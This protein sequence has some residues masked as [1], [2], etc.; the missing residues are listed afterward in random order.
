M[1]HIDKKFIVYRS[2]AGSGKTFTLVREYLQLVLQDPE[3]FRH[4]LA[5][6]FTN[7]AANEMKERIIRY[8]KTLADPARNPDTV[9]QKFL[10]PELAGATGLSE[11]AIKNRA[12][13]AL[14]SLMHQY[15]DFAVST[16][17]SF[18]H[19]VVRTFAHDLNIPLS[20]EVVL[21]EIDALSEVVSLL[22]DRV[23]VDE[24]LTRVLVK[25]IQDK[26]EDERSWDIEKDLQK[27]SSVLVRESS[28]PYLERVS[29]LD[30]KAVEEARDLIWKLQRAFEEEVAKMAIALLKRLESEGLDAADMAGGKYGLMPWL[31]KLAGK[32]FDRLEPYKAIF[33]AQEKDFWASAK[34]GAAKKA[35][36]ESLSAEINLAF[37]ALHRF[38]EE[39]K[40][41]Y[42][43]LKVITGYLYPM[44]VLGA[45]DRELQQYRE[46]NNVLLISEFNR[47][48]NEIIREQPVPFIYER[49]G[50]KY[51]HFMI[52]EFQDTSLL[53]WQNLLPLMENS[54]S[55]GRMNL[56]VGD[57]KQAIY[58]FRSGDVRQFE[59]LP[60]MLQPPDDPVLKSREDSLVRNFGL[61][62]LKDNFRS[63]E[64]VVSFNNLFFTRAR[65]WLPENMQNIFEDVTQGISGKAGGYVSIDFV[66]ADED[67]RKFEEVMMD[68]VRGTVDELLA[69]GFKQ[70]DIAILC[71]DNKNTSRIA[72]MLISN[73]RQVIS[74]DSL[75]L[76]FSAEVNFLVA[77]LRYLSNTADDISRVHILHYLVRKGSLDDK[78]LESYLIDTQRPD[79]WKESEAFTR[80][81]NNKFNIIL[82]KNFGKQD[83]QEWLRLDLYHLVGELIRLFIPLKEADPYLQFFHDQVLEFI[84]KEYHSLSDFL[85][86]WDDKGNM[87]SIVTPEGLDA[88]RIMTIHK[89]KGLEFPVVI[90]PFADTKLKLTLDNVWVDIDDEQVSEKLPFAYINVSKNR[91]AGTWYEPVYQEE[92]EKS[93]IDLYDLVYVAMTRPRDQLYVLSSVPPLDVS[94]VDS[95]PKMLKRF[96][97]EEEI[98]EDDGRSYNFGEMPDVPLEGGKEYTDPEVSALKMNSFSDWKNRIL[99][100]RSAPESWDA[101]NPE[102]SYSFGNKVHYVL[103]G[104]DY[105]EDLKPAIKQGLLDGIVSPDE[106][107]QIESMVGKVLSDPNTKWLFDISWEVKNEA[108]IITKDGG[109]YRPDRL[110]FK[111]KQAVVVDYKT[112]RP[113]DKHLDQVRNYAKLLSEMGYTVDKSLVLYLGEEVKAVEAV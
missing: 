93:L 73:G 19:R 69:R 35:L 108:E 86:W 89:A 61:R 44:A 55:E 36:L 82:E 113:N 65:Q 100:R 76:S 59:M 74:A 109:I 62:V 71:R 29:G 78:E 9:V 112:G 83:Y 85:E 102:R 1:E 23:G 33:T 92:E 37:T 66:E 99:L 95:V 64:E 105:P 60:R 101:E 31:R 94:S 12:L 97:V 57:G 67:G 38:I 21:E 2:S 43:T 41:R 58:R 10:L 75:I 51:Q 40:T 46:D 111:G 24:D 106:V 6:T 13:V 14:R 79:R 96:L 68:R 47:R 3:S 7:K 11:S 28:I 32:D 91:L 80:Y 39:G 42:L 88:I 5:I 45:L 107:D 87:K 98:W 50:E 63:R 48:I 53:Q 84:R 30:K 103:S 15:A 77:W 4:I 20:F 17:D 52:D 49:L 54:L 18:F 70:E 72:A 16:I 110:M 90:Y 34:A 8:L 22:L 81:L 27:F 56:V 26:A 104:M 25:F